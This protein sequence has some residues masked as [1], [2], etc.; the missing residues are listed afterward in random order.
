MQLRDLPEW[1]LGDLYADR[2]SAEFSAALERV[3][4]AAAAFAAAWRGKI[5]GV[6]GAKLATAIAEYE[7]I[8]DALGR[9]T[10]YA[11][12]LYAADMTDVENGQFYQT[13]HERVTEITSRL[14][15]LTIE[16]NRLDDVALERKLRSPALRH[17]APWLR[18][19][20]VFRPYQLSEEI[21]QLFHEKSV[22]GRA[23]WVRL[24]DDTLANFRFR[25][26]GEERNLEGTLHLLSDKDSATR[27]EAANKLAAT[28]AENA[29]LFARITNTLIKDKEIEDKWRKLPSPM[30]ARH[31]TNH[32]E[33][34]MVEA[35]VGAVKNAYPTLAHRYYRLKARWLGV[36]KLNYWDRNA[37]LPGAPE[38]DIPW[39]EGKVIVLDAYRRFSPKLAEIGNRFF[40]RPWIDAALRPGKAP[41]AF[42]HP[43]VPSAHP[44]LLLNYQGK[45][46]DVMTLAHELGHGIHQCLAAPQG[47]L[48]ADTPLTLAETA[49]VFGEQLTFQALLAAEPDAAKRRFMLA[50][51]VEDMLNTVVRQ[52]AF[53][54]FERRL[55]GERRDGELSPERIGDIW[56]E[57]QQESL[58]PAF[59]L[60]PEYRD[61]W[62]YI[63]H[64][65]HSPFYVYAYAFGDCLVNALYAAYQAAPDGFAGK[66][67]ALL[68]A[69]GTLHHRELL[70]PF[71]LDAGDAKFW[72]K[73]LSVIGG[74]IDRLEQDA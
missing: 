27:K 45:T 25:V 66:Y 20:R 5:K 36:D 16:I 53:H 73:G 70:A 47:P 37:P 14:L 23:A 67:L 65:V 62:I 71:G 31:L 2:R 33:P 29:R 72:D 63:S 3:A 42:A 19:V 4:T 22:A 39:S 64:F 40:E 24:F 74:M 44:Y 8:E 11:E 52:I 7:D 49:S 18:D 48:M 55:H 17:Y 35:L 10:S 68:K 12:L 15:F 59:R 30:T 1:D 46:R 26:G 69:G 28:F 51:K 38:R 61:Y 32:V 57:T 43:T 50:S 60:D 41:G 58:G 21:E 34:E 56:L 6:S 13:V 54:E 9:I